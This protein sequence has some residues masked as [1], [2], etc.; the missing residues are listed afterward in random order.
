[1]IRLDFAYGEDGAGIRFHIG[2]GEKEDAQKNR[3]R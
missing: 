2:G 3:V 1:M